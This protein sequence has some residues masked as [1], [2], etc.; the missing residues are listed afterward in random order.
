MRHEEGR[1]SKTR[2]EKIEFAST[3]VYMR[4]G[5]SDGLKWEGGIEAHGK[6]EHERVIGYVGK[7]KRYDGK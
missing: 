2:V 4:G 1:E 6:S 5:R 7:P 3:M